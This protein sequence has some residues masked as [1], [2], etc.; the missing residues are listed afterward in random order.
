MVNKLKNISFITGVASF[1]L[2][3]GAVV[4][5]FSSCGIANLQRTNTGANYNSE[6]AGKGEAPKLA[7]R[8][9]SN[10]SL[11]DEDCEDNDRCKETCRDI[12]DET[13]SYKKCYNLSIQEVSDIEDV[14]YTLLSADADDLE[15]LDS[16]DLEDYLRIGLDGWIDKLIPRQKQKRDKYDKFKRILAWIVEGEKDIVSVLEKEDQDNEILKKL[17]LEYCDE[18]NN[19]L[20]QNPDNDNLLR[21]NADSFTGK[22]KL[23]I[24]DSS[25]INCDDY[26]TGQSGWNGLFTYLTS[27]TNSCEVSLSGNFGAKRLNIKRPDKIE[28][29]VGDNV[30][31]GYN[32]CPASGQ[33]R[34][35]GISPESAR[36]GPVNDWGP[37]NESIGVAFDYSSSDLY[38]CGYSFVP[39]AP[40][41]TCT[42]DINI[43]VHYKQ[44][45]EVDEDEKEL[46]IALAGVGKVFFD[47]A[48][49]GDGTAF[50]LGNKL[51]EQACDG[52]GN[53]SEAQCIRAFYC[54]VAGRVTGTTNIDQDFFNKKGREA[55]GRTIDLKACNY[56]DEFD[57]I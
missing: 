57:R 27:T 10:P 44:I 4:L 35:S 20:C 37:V 25:L 45:A 47:T 46:F 38:Y 33:G 53:T 1:L 12:Y 22:C 3:A 34:L 14:F 29:L 16:D 39:S 56:V 42:R 30:H 9:A 55:I 48:A 32:V 54:W 15:D 7:S 36:L 31:F 23:K 13:S 2:I 49:D 24:T 41:E 18:G 51:V 17:F 43:D 40:T 52:G 26:N 50:A 28:L 11:A 19:H 6:D 21:T 8:L 5:L